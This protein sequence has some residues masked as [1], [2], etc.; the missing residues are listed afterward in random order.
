[1]VERKTIS[2]WG[3]SPRVDAEIF[4]AY[5]PSDLTQPKIPH[6]FIPQGSCRSYGDACLAKQVVS[7]LPLHNFLEFDPNRGLIKCEAGITLSNILSFIIP[8]GYFL[9]VTPGTKN[10][11]IG[12]CLAADVHGKNHHKEGSIANFTE[13][14]K[15]VLA[16]GTKIRCS[17]DEEAELFWA[18]L[19]GMGLTGTI[20]SATLRLKSIST[21]F[22]QTR[23]LKVKNLENLCNYFTDDRYQYTYSVAWIDTLSSQVGRSLLMLGE[24]A[25]HTQVKRPSNMPIHSNKSWDIPFFFPNCAL[26]SSSMRIFNTLYYNKQIRNETN[27]LIHYDPY[28]YPLDSIGS[29][30]RIYGREG[31]LQYQFV[32]P[33]D[34]GR[35]LIRLILKKISERGVLSFLSILKTLGDESG[36][37][38]SFP[39]PGYT[40]ALDIPLKNKS[41]IE[42]LSTLTK[43][44]IGSGGRIY[45][46]KDAIISKDDF[47]AMYPSH[48]EFRRIKKACDPHMSLRSLQS[49]RLGIT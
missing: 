1:M 38:L 20:Y 19:G 47:I 10:P 11:T 12:G 2:G 17:R 4:P 25:D 44:I 39:K 26:N 29:W 41:V 34:G 40:L 35:D 3:L 23:T 9:P 27:K 5:F 21:S 14:F 16:D 32:V 42:F 31:F 22:V 13:E 8:R 15:L 28:F 49:D 46:A 36:G 45:L 33:F 48:N 24:H 7:T 18:T 6:P 43:E 30:N 37:L